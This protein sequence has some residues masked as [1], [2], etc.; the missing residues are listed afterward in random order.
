MDIWEVDKLTLFLAFVIPGFISLKTYSLMI[1][2]PTRNS[3]DQLIDALAYSCINYAILW[4]PIGWI[5]ASPLA[6]SSPALYYVFYLV[7]FVFAPIIWVL[8][9]KWLRT[10][11]WVSQRL[12][13]PTGKAWDF[14]FQQRKSLPD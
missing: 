2:G 10:R 13:H 14:F 6:S 8:A 12:P 5:E 9:L 1:P 3:G 7:V 11:R 4:V